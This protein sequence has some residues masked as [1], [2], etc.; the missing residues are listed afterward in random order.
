[1]SWSANSTLRSPPSTSW[2]RRDTTRGQRAEVRFLTLLP[3]ISTNY[4]KPLA[5]AGIG[6]ANME[7]VKLDMDGHISIEALDRGLNRCLAEH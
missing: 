3:L 2:P 7:G 6:S 1:M 5:I 4:R